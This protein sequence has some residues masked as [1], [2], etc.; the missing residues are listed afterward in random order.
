M[1]V[2]RALEDASVSPRSVST[3]RNNRKRSAEVE[4]PARD[5]DIRMPPLST[6]AA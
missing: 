6:K 4:L 2:L 5:D 1:F 3:A